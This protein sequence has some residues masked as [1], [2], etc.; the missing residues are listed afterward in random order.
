LNGLLQNILPAANADLTV[1]DLDPV[2]DG[3]E[4]GLSERDVA[5]RQSIAHQATKGLD[6]ISWDYDRDAIGTPRP[7]QCGMR[8]LP[9]GLQNRDPIFQYVVHLGDTLLDHLVQ[10]SHPVIRLIC[11]RLQGRN[12]IFDRICALRSKHRDRVF[13]GA[14]SC[15]D[16]AR[17]FRLSWIVVD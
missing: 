9:V 16:M 14:V 8:R 3:A 11:S 10:P 13:A 15:A 12:P 5:G 17:S 7:V 4:I 6:S 2:D 1:V